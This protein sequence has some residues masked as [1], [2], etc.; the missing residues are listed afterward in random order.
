M[1]RPQARDDA[2]FLSGLKDLEKLFNEGHYDQVI[3]LADQLLAKFGVF[4]CFLSLK[5]LAQSNAGIGDQEAYLTLQEALRAPDADI[6]DWYVA[7]EYAL[8]LGRFDEAADYFSQAINLSQQQGDDY[9]LS[10]CYVLRPYALVQLGK[11]ELART[12]LD[13]VGDDEDSTITWL[14]KIGPISKQSVLKSIKKLH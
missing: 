10:C 13:K 12:D 2:P 3:E 1:S 7:G 4:A 5:A 11:T 8:E 9:Y 6:G 14:Y